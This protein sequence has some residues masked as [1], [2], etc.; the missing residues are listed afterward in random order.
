VG[1]R[2][3]RAAGTEVALKEAARQLFAE[4]G[5]LNTKITD[6]TRAAGR[7]T[8]SFYE[9]FA[10][11]EALLT[12]L[13][14]DVRGQAR[15]E[16]TAQPHPADHDLTDRAQLRA[17]LA[18]AWHTMRDNFPVVAAVHEAAVAAG[19]G[20]GES[21]RALASDTVILRDH[22]ERLRQQGHELP[23]DPELVAAAM[24]GVLATLAFAVLPARP[25]PYD[26]DQVIDTV[27]SLLLTG[28]RGLEPGPGPDA[29]AG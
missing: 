5:Y 7:A 11:K 24:G 2:K 27:T 18:A 17:H 3:E 14:D 28:L 8:G 25:A 22:L 9:H 15:D 4:R 23:G 6:I 26:D 16:I 12:A 13:L 20:S 10:S 21:W 29:D 1:V 19:P